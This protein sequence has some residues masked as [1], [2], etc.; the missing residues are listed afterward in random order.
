MN[1]QSD[2]FNKELTRRT[3]QSWRIPYWKKKFTSTTEGIN[4]RLDGTEKQIS[5]LE[6]RVVKITQVEQKKEKNNF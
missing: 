4:N 1:E 6:D 2:K 3:K 5:E